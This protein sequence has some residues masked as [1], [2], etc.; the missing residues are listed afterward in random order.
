MSELNILINTPPVL[1]NENKI[2]NGE[3]PELQESSFSLEEGPHLAKY[4]DIFNFKEY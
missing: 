3:I 2:N 1:L 4:F